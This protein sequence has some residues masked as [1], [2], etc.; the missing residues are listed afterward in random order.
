MY[1]IPRTT[2]EK[3]IQR[4]T[5]IV[6]IAKSKWNFKK[7]QITQRKAERIKKIN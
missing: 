1:V 3:S 6:T 4:D 5:L 2:T 7:V